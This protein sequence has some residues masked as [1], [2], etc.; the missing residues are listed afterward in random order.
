MKIL[1][2]CR[3]NVGRSQFAEALYKKYGDGN[4]QVSSAGT[5]VRVPGEK[6]S[7]IPL[8]A[9]VT[10]S[11]NEEGIDVSQNYTKQLTEEIFNEADQVVF[12]TAENEPVPDYMKNS[13][14]VTYW[15][16][17]NPK[18]T[19]FEMHRKIRDQIKELIMSSL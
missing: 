2:V 17:P 13:D 5:T 12:I 3:G 15:S 4:N 14:K 11:M 18:G 8:A 9:N 16:I 19:D 1:F 6:I 7:E 10:A